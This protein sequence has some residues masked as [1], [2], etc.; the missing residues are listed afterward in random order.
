MSGVL[1]IDRDG[2]VGACEKSMSANQHSEPVT[3]K[4]AALA[5]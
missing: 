4:G 2:G 3:P 1:Q 5:S